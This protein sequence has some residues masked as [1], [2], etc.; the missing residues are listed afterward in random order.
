M[1]GLLISFLGID[2]IGKTTLARALAAELAAANVP[3]RVVSWRSALESTPDP[4]PR[5]PLQQLWLETFRCLYAGSVTSGERPRL[6]PDYETWVNDGWEGR[7]AALA[8]DENAP[9]GALAAAFA[10]LAGSIILSTEVIQPALRDQVVV[11][12]ETFPYKHVLKE[13]IVAEKLAD[14]HAV[15]S[16]K[17]MARSLRGTVRALF[18]APPLRPD[19]GVLVDGSSKLAQQWRTAQS[20]GPG[21]LEDLGIVGDKGESSF[22]DLQEETAAEFRI[23]AHDAGWSVHTV[24]DSG[25]DQNIARG[26]DLVREHQAV[27]AYL[28]HELRRHKNAEAVL[29]EYPGDDPVVS[30]AR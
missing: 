8:V 30:P 10:E 23:Y 15:P 28:H 16:L 4:W 26:L 25:I 5:Q 2:G 20:G 9:G 6:P 1:T 14:E 18:C 22:V 27:A 7:L 21:V 29:P 19:I 17:D 24:D 11:I 3:V 12:Q 13:L